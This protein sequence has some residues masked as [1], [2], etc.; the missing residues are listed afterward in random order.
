MVH[1]DGVSP[2]IV[3]LRACGFGKEQWARP[4]AAPWSCV[5]CKQP[6][7]S[8]PWRQ[9]GGDKARVTSMQESLTTLCIFSVEGSSIVMQQAIPRQGI[10][11]N[12][13]WPWCDFVPCHTFGCRTVFILSRPVPSAISPVS[14]ANPFS[15][16]CSRL[17]HSLFSI[18]LTSHHH[19]VPSLLNL[20]S[21]SS[22][23]QCCLGRVPVPVTAF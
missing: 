20:T 11:C 16:V 3:C 8:D 15:R 17:C 13:G 9:G 5:E 21:A 22:P 18:P 7:R 10:V 14:S 12:G 2:P 4:K 6:E 1:A 23:M 19:F